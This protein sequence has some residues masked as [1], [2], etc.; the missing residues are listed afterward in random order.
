MTPPRAPSRPI[1]SERLDKDNPYIYEYMYTQFISGTSCFYLLR[2]CVAA[3][4]GHLLHN[5]A[6]RPPPLTARARSVPCTASAHRASSV[7]ARIAHLL[8]LALAL[9]ALSSPRLALGVDLSL[10]ALHARAGC[11]EHTYPYAWS[12]THPSH[13]HASGTAPAPHHS[14]PHPHHDGGEE[15][16]VDAYDSPP[17]APGIDI[18]TPHT[19]AAVCDTTQF[20]EQLPE[21]LPSLPRASQCRRHRNSVATPSRTRSARTKTLRCPRAYATETRSC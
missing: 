19:P 2:A 1:A 5:R 9:S 12:G 18:V 4:A 20:T 10:A 7:M 15:A 13:A 8:L 14:T 6:P 3:A 11:A 17:T 16:Y 21:L